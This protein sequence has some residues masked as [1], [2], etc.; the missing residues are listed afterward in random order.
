MLV[1]LRAMKRLK[2]VKVTVR[3]KA[4][5]KDIYQ[6]RELIYMAGI[7]ESYGV[8][9]F[10]RA[11]MGQGLKL[12]VLDILKSSSLLTLAPEMKK[13]STVLAKYK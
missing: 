9:L 2:R 10:P 12:R 5:M 6:R 13:N 3:C 7:S 4:A 1:K 8:K 11:S